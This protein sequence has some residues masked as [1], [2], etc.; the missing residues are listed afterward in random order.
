MRQMDG[1][2]ENEKERMKAQDDSLF[3]ELY[4]LAVKL[5]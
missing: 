4:L 2:K 3:H 5:L 1:A